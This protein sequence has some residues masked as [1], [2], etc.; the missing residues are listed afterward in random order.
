MLSSLF[1]NVIYSKAVN[2]FITEIFRNIFNLDFP[3][4]KL[5]FGEG[6]ALSKHEIIVKTD[7]L[8]P[9]RFID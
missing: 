6:K 3:S 7:C 8:N 9:D 1:I 4:Q 5:C 2:T